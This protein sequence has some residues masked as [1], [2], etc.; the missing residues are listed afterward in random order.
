MRQITLNLK[1]KE[2]SPERLLNEIEITK[3][4]DIEFKKMVIRTQ[5][6]LSENFNNSREVSRNL[7]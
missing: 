7:L 6:E 4:S 2:E 1:R 3:V 5:K